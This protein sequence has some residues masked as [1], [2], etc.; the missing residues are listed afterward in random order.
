MN[1]VLDTVVG[2][3]GGQIH[4]VLLDP[5]SDPDSDFYAKAACGRVAP[6]DGWTFTEDESND[7]NR[8]SFCGR[9]VQRVSGGRN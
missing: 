7:A 6:F 2:P 9:C 8:N 1:A 4:Y 5:K 3:R